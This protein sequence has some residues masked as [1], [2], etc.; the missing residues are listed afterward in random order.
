MAKLSY[1]VEIRNDY[2]GKSKRVTGR[3][4]QEIQYKA[5]EQLLR[6]AQE[7][8]RARE[9]ATIADEKERA[10]QETDAVQARIEEYRGIL[11]ATLAVNDRISWEELTDRDP[12]PEPPPQL[13]EVMARAGVPKKKPLLETFK[14]AS[15]AK[16]EEAEQSARAEYERLVEAHAEAAKRYEEEQAERNAEVERFK[17]NYEDGEAEAVER[18][19]ALVLANSA[20]PEGFPREFNVQCLPD[21]R[22]AV[23][24]IELPSP[25]AVPD[26][27]SVV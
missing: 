26:R 25:D 1:Y 12:Y 14:L 21:E 8:D 2:L 10:A 22:S 15:A 16:R 3:S 17:R 24:D 6:W 5:T 4:R 7:E 20:Y 9:R 18:Y 13:E 27:K 19:L 11:E 23:V